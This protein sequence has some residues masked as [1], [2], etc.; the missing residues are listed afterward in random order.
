MQMKNNKTNPKEDTAA[1]YYDIKEKAKAVDA[2]ANADVTETPDYSKEELARYRSHRGFRISDAVKIVL[3][4]AWFAGAVCFFFLWG[5]GTYV[6]ALLDM[7]FITGIALGIATDLL[8]N[9]LIRFME[10]EP[11]ENDRWM[12]F[13]KK[14]MLSFFLNILYAFLLLFCVYML[15]NGI[16]LAVINI[17]GLPHDSVPLGVE[18]I[19]FGVFT[20]AFDMLFIG[21]KRLLAR[22]AR[23]AKHARSADGKT[24]T[25]TQ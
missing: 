14:G 5:L 20:M 23:N 19:L 15:Y 9:N 4:K 18:P 13:P 1:K 25:D 24:G 6:T 7:L 2:L 10:K 22:L 21:V 16:N 3:L 11:G 12:M 17:A 8:L